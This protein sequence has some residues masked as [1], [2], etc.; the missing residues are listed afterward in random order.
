MAEFAWITGGVI[1]VGDNS[2]AF[3]VIINEI[4]SWILHDLPHTSGGDEFAIYL[5][6]T[7]HRLRWYNYGILC[8]WDLGTYIIEK[9]KKLMKILNLMWNEM[10][11]HMTLNKIRKR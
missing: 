7:M 11:Y 10:F 2:I 9:K 3:V 8:S 6:L 5:Q 4:V 1:I